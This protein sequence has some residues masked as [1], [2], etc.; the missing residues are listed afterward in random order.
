MLCTIKR[1]EH[2]KKD[3]IISVIYSSKI[4]TSRDTFIGRG[5]LPTIEVLLRI[6]YFIFPAIEIKTSMRIRTTTKTNP[7]MV[8]YFLKT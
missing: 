8:S 4:H 3:L 7:N 1:F 2:K 6:Y 5:I